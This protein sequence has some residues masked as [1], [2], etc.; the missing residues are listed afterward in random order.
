LYQLKQDFVE[1]RYKFGERL[2][3]LELFSMRYS[4]LSDR[5]Y[6]EVIQSRMRP[7]ADGIEPYP[8]MVR[9][10]AKQ[11]HKRVRLVIQGENTPVDREILEKLEAP[12]TH[13]LRNAVDHGIE[14]PKE[15][16]LAGKNEEGTITLEASHKAGML[17]IVV[18]DDGRGVD[19]E[20]LRKKVIEKGFVSSAIGEKLNESELL[21]FIFLPGFSTSEEVTEIS[22]RGIGLNVVQT[23]VQEVG[24]TIKA[25]KEIGLSLKMQ[26]PLTLSVIRALLVEISGQPYA[27]PLAHMEKVVMLAKEDV[28]CIEHRQYIRDENVNIGLIQAYQVLN[29]EPPKHPYDNLSVIIVSDHMN[30]YGIVVDRFI[31]EKELVVQDMDPILGKVPDIYG[32]AF[33]E[34]GSPVLIIDVEDTVRSIDKLLSKG[35]LH[36]LNFAESQQENLK[37]KRILVVDDSVTVREIESKLLQNE[38]YEVDTAVNGVDGWNAVRLMNYDLVITDIDMPRMNGIELIK[39][40]RNDRKLEHL[41][42][43]IVSYKECEEDRIKAVQAGVD[44]FLTKNS[45]HDNSLLV[46]V[47]EMIG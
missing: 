32:G 30:R 11:L 15:R 2:A 17:F 33:M 41:P 29:L 27:I 31:S 7:F 6:A 12:I 35:D 34:D 23:M 25:T 19:I 26:L 9:D 44:F 1:C 24:G 8:R 43:M 10:L 18:T 21:E 16:K 37:K 40:I 42:V 13:L 47:K 14:T 22:G 36:S 46:A 20:N 38:G 45:F 4:S 28:L 39:N 5:L 3:D